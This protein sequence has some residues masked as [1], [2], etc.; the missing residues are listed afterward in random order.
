[1]NRNGTEEPPKNIEV[2][3]ANTMIIQFQIPTNGEYIHSSN[4]PEPP[5]PLFLIQKCTSDLMHSAPLFG[6][7]KVCLN[8]RCYISNATIFKVLRCFYY[9]KNYFIHF[10]KIIVTLIIPYPFCLFVIFSKLFI[11][12]WEQ[13]SRW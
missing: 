1:M 11:P 2:L 13:S 5:T 9:T 7:M 12:Q 3:Q 8:I 4:L 6:Q 10:V